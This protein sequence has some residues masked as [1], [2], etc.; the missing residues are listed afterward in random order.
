MGRRATEIVLSDAERA[1]LQRW[2]RRRSGSSGLY[3]RAGIVLDC[4]AGLSGAEIAERHRTSQQT[5]TKWRRRFASGRLAGLSDA[6]R[7]GQPRR[8]G[9]EQV[10]VVLDATLNRRPGNA[11]HWSVR[12]LSAELG[13]PR[14]FVH[15]VWRAFGLKPHLSHSFKLST[16]PH[17]VAKV[18]D[19][20]G[21]YLD[22]PDKALV[23]CVDEK[24]Q[25]QALERTQRSLPLNWGTPE[26]RTAEREAALAMLGRRDRRRGVTL[27]ADKAYDV[28]AFVDALRDRSVTPHIAVDGRLSK[29]G[30]RRLTRIDRRTTR[31]PGY[32]ASQRL[33]KRI[34]EGFGWIKTTGGLAKTRHR[35]LGRV[36]WMFTLAEVWGLRS[37]GSNPCRHVKRYRERM[38]ER[39][40][41]PEETERLGEVLR[42]A[43]SE[44]PSAVCSPSRPRSVSE[45]RPCRSSRG[46][47]DMFASIG[48]W[49]A[50]RQTDGAGAR[51]HGAPRPDRNPGPS[52]S[53]M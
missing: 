3:V 12:S 22:P 49:M 36:G 38:R 11:T 47:P 17:F 29:L 21:L 30:K 4:A 34:E 18:R 44:M 46:K 23:L 19:V 39:F 27:G 1:E 40:L 35:G 10:Q 9:D 52:I 7:T 16:D 2:R 37:D 8:H 14:D 26:T 45:S 13:V 48:G 32:A 51:T 20:V 41:S 50:G 15:R 25:I 24:S 31:H 6:P 28:A 43:E 33:R 53:G 5:V 42:E